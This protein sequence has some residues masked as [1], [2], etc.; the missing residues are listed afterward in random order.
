[1][2]AISPVIATLILIA[3]A[4]IAGVFVLRQFLMV[5]GN[6]GTQQYLQI[7]DITFFKKLSA[8]GTK[9]TI[10]LSFSVKNVG[11][12]QITIKS[13]SVPDA[14]F[15]QELN[16][17]LNPG[18]V[19]TDS[20]VVAQDMDY[21]INWETG[22]EHTVIITYRVAGTPSDQQVSEKGTVR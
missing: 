1:M 10:T 15:T 2:K 9:M 17:K 16:V 3:I 18:D 20:Y 22:T 13:V 5:A 11:D 7:Q 21:T 19:H 12:K 8:D 4:V 6:I 14:N